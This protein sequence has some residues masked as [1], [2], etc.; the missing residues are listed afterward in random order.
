[1][2]FSEKYKVLESKFENQVDCDNRE[3]DIQSEY[4]RNFIPPGPVDYVLIAMEPSTGVPWNMPAKHVAHSQIDRN[5]SLSVEDF[6]LHFSIRQ[7]LCQG[8]KTYHLTDLAKGGMKTKKAAVTLQRYERWY[9]ILEEELRLLTKPEGTRIIA[10]GKVV[11]KFLGNK[12]LCERVESVLHY[13]RTAA[14]YRD[15]RIKP[16]REHFQEFCQSFDKSAFEGSIRDVLK[17]ADMDSYI[18][19]CRPE[20]DKPYGL[21]ESRMKLLFY[22]KNRFFQLQNE[23]SIVLKSQHPRQNSA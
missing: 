5:F 6:I 1:M 2:T 23:S 9:P 13:T 3:L 20:G 15:S 22:Y 4:V 21:T 16:W 18:D 8:E 19:C 17:D 14:G 10:I 11:A 7:Y 12:G